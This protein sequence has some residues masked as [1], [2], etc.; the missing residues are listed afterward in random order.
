MAFRF[1]QSVYDVIGM[2]LYQSTKAAEPYCRLCS[3]TV[4]TLGGQ[5]FHNASLLQ[6][7][8]QYSN[9]STVCMGALHWFMI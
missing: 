3:P 4:N 1:S 5:H 8:Q 6:L 2:Y 7:T 9:T